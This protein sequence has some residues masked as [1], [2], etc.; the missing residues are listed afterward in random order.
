M[1]VFGEGKT[2]LVRCSLESKSR[3]V[4]WK[5]V[6][7][8]VESLHQASVMSFLFVSPV[9]PWKCIPWWNPAPPCHWLKTWLAP[10]LF[11]QLMWNR[12]AYGQ[13][14]KHWLASEMRNI[15]SKPWI[16]LQTSPQLRPVVDGP[17]IFGTVVW[18][19]S[20][21]S[22]PFFLLPNCIFW[23]VRGWTVVK[24]EDMKVTRLR[25]TRLPSSPDSGGPQH[26]SA[27][28]ILIMPTSPSI[29]AALL[30]KGS[31]GGGIAFTFILWMFCSGT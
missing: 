13:S 24:E 20:H 7:Y 8:Y 5:A 6:F 29:L 21:Y 9:T 17:P 25:V 12:L 19:T 26:S 23:P 14:H 22:L 28:D 27:E 10:W 2:R 1:R 31:K 30:P 18:V 16:K 3:Q 15:Q 4:F 11:W